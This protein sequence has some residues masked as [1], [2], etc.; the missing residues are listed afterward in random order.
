MYRLFEK[1]YLFFFFSI[2][3]FI[4][5]G[6]FLGDSTLHINLHDTYF[7]I[8]HS[9]LSFLISM[10]S[11][12]IAIGYWIICKAK[13]RLSRWLNAIHI[14]LNIG[15][16]VLFFGVSDLAVDLQL[17]PS[18]LYYDK[19]IQKNLILVLAL[20]LLFIAQLAYIFNLLYGVL[21]IN[22]HYK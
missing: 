15:G 12:V 10:C 7:I 1:P 2:P 5:I 21:G 18:G 20:S 6:L 8:L 16:L 9:H 17:L 19:F 14:I 22:E 11:G 13:K 3:I 4:V